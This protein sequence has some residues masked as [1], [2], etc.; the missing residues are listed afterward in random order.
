MVAASAN[1]N[2][3]NLFPASYRVMAAGDAWPTG[4]YH[5]Q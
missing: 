4:E 5:L 2:I 3:G 1:L